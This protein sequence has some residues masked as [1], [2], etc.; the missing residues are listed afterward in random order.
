MTYNSK[1]VNC[2]DIST[3]ICFHKSLKG[4][5]FVLSHDCY[6]DSLTRTQG[7]AHVMITHTQSVK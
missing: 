6:K 1:H 4:L 3:N 7:T 2:G 5:Q